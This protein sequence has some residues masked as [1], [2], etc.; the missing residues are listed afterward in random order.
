MRTK[1]V[2]M[3]VAVGECDIDGADA[4]PKMTINLVS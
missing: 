1:V 3:V 4:E 2:A